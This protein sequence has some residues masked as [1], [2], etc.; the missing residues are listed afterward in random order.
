MI[1]VH[2]PQH[3]YEITIARGALAEV[4]PWVKKLWAPQQV[5]V[6]TDSNV[7]LLYSQTVVEQLSVAGFT[8][9]LKVVPAGEA[10]KSL[11]QA[12]QLYNFLAENNFTRSDGVIA[13]GGGVMGDLAAFVASTYMRGLHFLQ[14]PT[15]LLAQ[16]DSSIGGKTAVNTPYAKNMVG[17]FA[18]PDAVLI[19]PNVLSTLEMR[20][21][22]EGIAEIVKSA[23]IADV[24]FWQFLDRLQ[25]ENDLL[26]HSEE[27]I[28]YALEVKRHAVEA[29]VL[30]KGLRL[31]LNFGHTIGHAIENTAG[32]GVVAHGEGVAIGMV[33]ITKHAEKVGLT[34][35]GTTA[36]LTAML[37]KFHLPTTYANWQAD[38]FYQAIVHDKKARGQNLKIILL[39]Q[40]GQAKI[41]VIPLTEIKNYL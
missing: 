13:L 21:V 11:A 37:E 15:T 33:A 18:Q 26:A 34:P 38:K 22:R 19:D 14:I 40:I 6:I 27:V 10:S 12:E 29:D 9:F 7:A 39:E 25:D 36:Q 2:L 41:V 20:R 16:V 30:D 3:D 35:V 24:D 1:T 4:G 8:V 32:Y 28:H 23:A 31:T 17:T 5:A